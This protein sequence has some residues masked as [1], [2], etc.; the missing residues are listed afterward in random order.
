[1]AGGAE[2]GEADQRQEDGVEAGD[3]GRAGNA[4]VT[5]DLRDVHRGQRDAGEG[6]VDGAAAGEG[7]EPA[8]ER[9]AHSDY[10]GS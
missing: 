3:G 7:A 9:Q 8:E 1:M 5:E 10:P 4:G 2:N 6:V